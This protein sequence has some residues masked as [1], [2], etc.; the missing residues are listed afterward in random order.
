MRVQVLERSQ[1]QYGRTTIPYGIRRSGRRGT[2]AVAVEPSG[3]VLLTAPTS[4][5]VD[6]LDRLVH[7]KARWIVARRRQAQALTVPSPGREFISGETF[8]YLGRQYRLLVRQGATAARLYRGRLEVHAPGSG[9]TRAQQVRAALIGW[10]R[11]QATRRLAARVRYWAGRLGVTVRSVLVR[12]Q[13]KRWGS[14]DATGDVRLNWRI[15]QASAGLVD[16]VV[17]HE[18]VHLRHRDHGVAFWRMLGR[19][20]PD[21]EARRTA[22]KR[23][24]GQ[25]QW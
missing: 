21:Y 11:Q 18:L 5:P 14:C 17:A 12:E 2:V 16:Y 20:M 10:Y 19:A 3:E 4:T 23:W 8:F 24:G 15:M 7:Q 25:V 6:R 13:Q 1:V 22:L 9:A